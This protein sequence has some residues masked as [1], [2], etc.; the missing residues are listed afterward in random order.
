MTPE[1]EEYQ[2][3]LALGAALHGAIIETVTSHPDPALVYRVLPSTLA[4]LCGSHLLNMQRTKVLGDG[5]LDKAVATCCE[6][7]RKH[8][9]EAANPPPRSKPVDMR[10]L[11]EQMRRR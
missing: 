6:A 2:A 4:G 9:D 1:E 11:R 8:A 7:L 10:H 5:E 3:V